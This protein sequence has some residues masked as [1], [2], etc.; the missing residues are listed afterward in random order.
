MILDRS[1]IR[2]IAYNAGFR[3]SHLDAAVEIAYCESGFNTAAHC[4]NCFGVSEDSRGLWQINVN[5][6]PQYKSVDLFDPQV[7]A[8]AAYQIYLESG[9]DFSPWTC[10]HKL[11]L[12][13]P[14]QKKSDYL[15]LAFIIGIVL[16]L[17]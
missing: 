2:N 15:A 4:L 6:H 9:K 5:A 13:N 1:M 17:K 3:G 16:Y 7:N 14:P 11:G 10:A 8:N 12:I